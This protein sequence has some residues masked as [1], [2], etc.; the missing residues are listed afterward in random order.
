MAAPDIKDIEYTRGD[1]A[2][3]KFTLVDEND[4]PISIAGFSFLMT[5]D[6]DPD[7]DDSSAN[8]F[9]LVGAI[10]DAPTGEFQFAPTPTES[11]KT[12]DDYFHDIQMIDGSS[13]IRTI[14]KGKFGLRQDVTK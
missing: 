5:V 9:Q 1:S 11:D 2:P 7:P 3:M 4:D 6:P 10:I 8:I 13:A 12:P 14:S